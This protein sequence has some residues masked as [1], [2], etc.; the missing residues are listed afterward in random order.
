MTTQNKKIKIG[1]VGAGTSGAISLLSILDDLYKNKPMHSFEIHL[2]FD[3]NKPKLK[4]GEGLSPLVTSLLVNTLG[5][6]YDETNL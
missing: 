3:S 1:I 2:F 4:V 5:Y 6:E